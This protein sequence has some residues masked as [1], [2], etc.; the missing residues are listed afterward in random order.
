MIKWA[1]PCLLSFFWILPRL[2]HLISWKPGGLT[3]PATMRS[4]DDFL[5]II[6]Q[7][8]NGRVIEL[9]CVKTWNGRE[10]KGEV[11][12]PVSLGF[13][14]RKGL[15]PFWNT[16]TCTVAE[17]CS[18]LCSGTV[19]FFSYCRYNRQV[20]PASRWSFE[21]LGDAVVGGRL[22]FE[23]QLGFLFS[24]FSKFERNKK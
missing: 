1:R 20:T 11:D 7:L 8:R 10:G 16:V 5:Y 22:R 6:Q 18:G 12:R 14:D 13:N 3:R 19:S 21:D 2:P 24:Y 15:E 4:I 9:L 17:V 23:K